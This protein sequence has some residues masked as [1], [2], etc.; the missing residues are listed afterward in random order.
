MAERPALKT[1]VLAGGMG[2]RLFPLSREQYPKQ[3]IPLFDGET[4]FQKTV[5]RALLFSSPEGIAIVTSRHHRFLVR[6]QL[7][8]ICEGCRILAEPEGRN[9]LP[10]IAW[11]VRELERAHGPSNVAVLPSDHLVTPGEEY[12]N[13]LL[14]ASQLADRYL[15]TFGVSPTHA[16]TGYGYILPGEKVN[17]GFLVERFVEKPDAESAARYVREGYLWNSG[18]FLFSSVVFDRECRQHAP[19]IAEAFGED[20]EKD[21][22][23]RVPSISMDYGLMEKTSRAAVVPLSTGWC[24]LGSFDSLYHA[25][26]K[27]R[28]GNVTRGECIPIESQGNLVLGE[29]L[30]VTIGLKDIAVVDTRDVLLV[31]RR[32]DSERVREVV[33]VLK[34]RGDERASYHLQVH[35]PWGS[36]TVLE[37]G[38]FYTIK[39]ITVLPGRKL[40]LQLHHHRSEHWV[41]VQG[42]A[43][44]EVGERRHLLRNGESTFVPSGMRHRL[45]NPGILP[46]EIIEV[47]IGEY[48]GEDDIVRFEDDFGR[49]NGE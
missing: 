26:P 7:Q 17:G 39:R 44:I 38:R 42:T 43:E 49:E 23:A 32:Q 47:Q 3:F 8:G 33:E 6:D 10:A 16:H 28:E 18:I 12:R 29:R 15:V 9:T 27:D 48:I 11:G 2:T 20:A 13:A 22:Y 37:R 40:S 4:L 14:H 41:V 34:R 19:G 24:D 5:K 30:V 21:A 35:R 31:G 25:F 1:I 45:G 46:L 36:Y